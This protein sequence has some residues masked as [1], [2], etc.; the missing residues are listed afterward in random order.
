MLVTQCTRKV[1]GIVMTDH[2]FKIGSEES[3]EDPQARGP[4][5]FIAI[6]GP[7]VVRIRRDERGDFVERDIYPPTHAI[8]EK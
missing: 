6:D 1:G 7:A 2:W 8:P 5:K 4:G 3:I